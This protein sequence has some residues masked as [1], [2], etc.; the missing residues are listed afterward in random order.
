MK[1]IKRVPVFLKHSVVLWKQNVLAT[2]WKCFQNILDHVSHQAVSSR[3][4]DQQQKTPD[5]RRCW[6]DEL[7]IILASRGL[8]RPM[9]NVCFKCVFIYAMELNNTCLRQIFFWRLL[10]YTKNSF[11]AELRPRSRPSASFFR[12][13]VLRDLNLGASLCKPFFAYSLGPLRESCTNY[14]F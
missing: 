2:V 13:P 9:S 3:Q 10:G 11:T 5:G 8:C 4:L 12:F 1:E 14:V 6:A 7:G